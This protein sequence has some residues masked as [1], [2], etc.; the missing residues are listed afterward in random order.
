MVLIVNKIKLLL[1]QYPGGQG[2][3]HGGGRGHGR[4]PGQDRAQG[5]E[6][7]GVDYL[8]KYELLYYDVL[9]Q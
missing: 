2:G 6:E 9:V 1:L 8:A 7:E 3:Q 4:P 5:G